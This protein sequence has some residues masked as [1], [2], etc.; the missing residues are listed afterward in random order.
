MKTD[1]KNSI[2]AP[3]HELKTGILF[4]VYR[5]LDTTRRVFDTI[6]EAQPPRLYIASDGPRENAAGEAEKVKKV[7]EY[8]MNN[9]D[10]DCNVKTLFREKN[11]GCRKAVSEAITWFFDNEKKGIILEDDCLPDR[12]FFRFCEELLEKYR[13]DSR[14]MHISGDNFQNGIRRTEDSYYFSCY[15]HVWGWASWRRAWKYYD[16]D[17]NLWDRADVESMLRRIGTNWKPFVKYWHKNFIDVHSE[18][19]DTWDYVWTFSCWM[20]DGLSVI[21]EVN[22]VENIGFGQEAT[23]TSAGQSG[24]GFLQRRMETQFPLKHPD[25]ITRCVAADRYTSRKHYGIRTPAERCVGHL[26]KTHFK[27]PKVLRRV[28]GTARCNRKGNQ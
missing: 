7:R 10:W 6:R 4:L 2:V 13:D 22:L 26:I 18:K 16:R 28:F 15:N 25:T 23:H 27:L 9:I 5:R 21:P 1:N 19:I 24:N 12:S 8:V 11:L 17:M 14:I 3:L 20:H